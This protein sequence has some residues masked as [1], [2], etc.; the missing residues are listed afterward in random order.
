M[1]RM[2]Y[3]AMTGAKS[4]MQAQTINTN[5]LANANTTGFKED[6]MNF[7][8]KEV[9]GKGFNTRVHSI[10]VENS[11][12]QASG[13]L[14]TTGR[15]LD[16]SVDGDGMIAVQSPTGEEAYT[17]A[18]NF[19]ITGS[20]LLVTKGGTPVLGNDGGPIAIPPSQKVEI[21]SDGTISV[22]PLGQ[23]ATSLAVVDRIKLVNPDAKNIEK[24][25]DGLFYTKSTD[26][27]A[28]DAKVKLVSGTL[29][30]S[31]VNAVEAMVN[32]ISLSRLYEADV[33]MMSNAEENDKASSK[34]LDMA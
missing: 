33:K 22:I 7:T 34:L 21:G 9:P 20:G 12:N 5:N 15:S 11:V 27:A 24:G 2:L 25:A 1:D 4:M 29:E 28:L 32:M 26:T 13:A 16:V 19:N 8:A 14:M 31:N 18:G 3:V 17:R 10:A 23:P 6:L 30:T